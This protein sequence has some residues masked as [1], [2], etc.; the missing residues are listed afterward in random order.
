MKLYYEVTDAIQRYLVTGAVEH[1]YKASQLIQSELTDPQLQSSVLT[2]DT[3]STQQAVALIAA[4][5]Y[6]R[7]ST[8]GVTNDGP[9]YLDKY[10]RVVDKTPSEAALVLNV[11]SITEDYLVLVPYSPGVTTDGNQSSS[12]G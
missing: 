11:A 4:K 9:V 10:I 1:L 6:L 7:M 2:L 8:S 5:G 3:I 12:M